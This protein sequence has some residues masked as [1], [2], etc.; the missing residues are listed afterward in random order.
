MR[1]FNNDGVNM[2]RAVRG[3]FLAGYYGSVEAREER[4]N[5]EKT[6]G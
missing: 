3:V 4:G 2:I 6:H 1:R 5:D